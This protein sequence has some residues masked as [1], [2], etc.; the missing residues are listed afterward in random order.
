MRGRAN[1][2]GMMAVG[3]AVAGCHRNGDGGPPVVDTAGTVGVTGVA[4]EVTV[5]G[6]VVF[7]GVASAPAMGVYQPPNPAADCLPARRIAAI[8]GEDVF[9]DAVFAGQFPAPG[10]Q[11][12]L[13]SSGSDTALDWTASTWRDEAGEG[14]ASLGGTATLGAFTQDAVEVT[15]DGASVCRSDRV[16][17][18]DPVLDGAWS[19]HTTEC[20]SGATVVFRTTEPLPFSLDRAPWCSEGRF[21]SWATPEGDRLCSDLAAPCE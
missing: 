18:A 12:V 13:P 6:V 8:Q 11:V 9:L 5:D 19:T 3:I 15:I 10:E 20:T 17:R 1:A 14:W 16:E 2:A 21:D 7:A 4:A